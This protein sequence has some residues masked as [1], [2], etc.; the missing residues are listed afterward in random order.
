MK[1]HD[2]LK[3]L[4]ELSEKHGYIIRSIGTKYIELSEVE[5]R[6]SMFYGYPSETWFCTRIKKDFEKDDLNT[7]EN[8]IIKRSLE[9]PLYSTIPLEE[10]Y[11][12]IIEKSIKIVEGLRSKIKEVK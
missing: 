4:I 7:L 2:K 12:Y 11:D 6:V 1:L 8:N 9:S 5:S 3:E 10:T